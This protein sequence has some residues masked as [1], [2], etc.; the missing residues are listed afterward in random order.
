MAWNVN[1]SSMANAIRRGLTPPRGASHP[2]VLYENDGSPEGAGAENRT[3]TIFPDI[4]TG[5]DH[6][7]EEAIDPVQQVPST[8]S[9]DKPKPL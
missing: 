3:P 8:P 7:G 6:V 9:Q 4:G 1:R 5:Q 2:R